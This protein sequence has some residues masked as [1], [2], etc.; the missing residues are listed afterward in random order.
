[1]TTEKLIEKVNNIIVSLPDEDRKAAFY[2]MSKSPERFGDTGTT[3][4]LLTDLLKDLQDD[5]KNEAAKAS[6]KLSA[7]K[8]AEKI[9]KQLEKINKSF[10]AYVS[11]GKQIIG[12][13]CS[14]VRLSEP[15]PLQEYPA[16]ETP[17]NY[18]DILNSTSENKGEA[19]TLPSLAELTAHNKTLKALN[20]HIKKFSPTYDFGEGLPAVDGEKLAEILTIL[21]SSTKAIASL[22][23]P[24]LKA[25]YFINES[26]DDALLMPVRKDAIKQ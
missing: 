5:L 3:P 6:G 2:T 19:L 18:V 13:S 4:A 12:G 17:L 26:G 25:I 14:C 8:A 11:D 10:G 1:M 16:G 22:H 20:K 15:L 9:F 21:G 7:K 23:S 24:L